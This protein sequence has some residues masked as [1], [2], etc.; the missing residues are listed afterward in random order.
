VISPGLVEFFAG[1]FIMK[2]ICSVFDLPFL[3]KKGNAHGF[4]G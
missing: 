3:A 1:Y 2:K 4:L